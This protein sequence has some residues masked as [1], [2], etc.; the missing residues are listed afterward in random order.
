MAMT[1]QPGV[2]PLRVAVLEPEGLREEAVRRA[3]NAWF[4]YT[5]EALQQLGLRAE[6]LPPMAPAE[7]ARLAPFSALLLPGLPA[8]AL[9]PSA[10]QHV[11]WADEPAQRAL[12]HWVREGGILIGLG[13]QPLPLAA[14]FGVQPAGPPIDAEPFTLTATLRL[15][16]SPEVARIHSP[17]H[18]Q[19]PLLLFSPLWP[20]VPQPGTRVLATA[21]DST[22]EQPIGAAITARRLGSGQAYL[23]AFD[24]PRTLWSLHKGRPATVDYDGDGYFRTSDMILIGH[25]AIEVAYADE[26]LFVLQSLLARRPHPFIAPFP[27]R[28]RARSEHETLT[29]AL[30]FWGGDDEAATNGL[31]RRASDVMA[32]RGLPYHINAM[33]RVT[34]EG[35]GPFGLSRKDAEAIRANG[36]EISLHYNFRDGVKHPYI[37]TPEAVQAQA[38]AFRRTFGRDPICTVNHC[39]HWSGW[40]EPAEWMRA[41]GGRADNSFIHK[42][43][44]PSN[45]VNLLGFGFGTAFPHYFYRDYRS[46]N[47]RIDFLEE[48]ITAYE[49]GYTR[50]S[51]DYALVHRVV[52]LAV[53]YGLT[54]NMFYYPVYIAEWPTCRQAIDEFLRYT[55]ARGVRAVHMGNDALWR[56]WDARARSAVQDAVELPDGTLRLAVFCAY[57]D[58][59]LV[60]IPRAARKPGVVRVN[61]QPAVHETRAQCGLDWLIFAVSAGERTVEVQWEV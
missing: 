3:E 59:M 23:F 9:T 57:P 54:M 39:T 14:L 7:P 42:Q 30:F 46:G 32:A 13:P 15:T 5:W 44:P 11:P 4:V 40:Y 27:P 34:P 10:A 58:G 24:L 43:S 45:P 2:R 60:R 21:Y 49:V 53:S 22:G 51:T 28:S 50:D 17:V 6:A 48:P 12:E 29:D 31:Q 25:H 18:P 1:L 52:D 38:E 41:A 55:A 61:G 37:I 19:Q 56:W 47:S 26:L 16:D 8:W 20:V 33:P 36:H 35:V